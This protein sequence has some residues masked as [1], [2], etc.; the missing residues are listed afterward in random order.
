MLGLKQGKKKPRRWLI[1]AAAFIDPRG[2][3]KGHVA[4]LVAAALWPYVVIL[5]LLV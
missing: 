3:S 5:L 4:P 2:T 1:L